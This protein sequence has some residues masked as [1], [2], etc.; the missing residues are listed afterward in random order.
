MRIGRQSHAVDNR[1]Q[2][3]PRRVDV[4]DVD[5]ASSGFMLGK[6]WECAMLSWLFKLTAG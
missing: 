1:Q 2:G 5:S 4:I 3:D 6:V